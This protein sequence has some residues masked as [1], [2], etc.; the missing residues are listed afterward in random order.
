MKIHPTETSRAENAYEDVLQHLTSTISENIAEDAQKTKIF[1]SA[2]ICTV[3]KYLRKLKESAYTP[4]L[5][6]INP[7]HRNEEH[8]QKPM[9]HVKMSY[10]DDL[11]SQLTM[12]MKGLELVEKKKAVLQ[13]CVA[14]AEMKKLLDDAKKCYA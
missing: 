14:P 8:L 1:S 9:K 10:T 4:R 7:L 2:C 6:A 12:V 3:P 13:E 5:F 11:V